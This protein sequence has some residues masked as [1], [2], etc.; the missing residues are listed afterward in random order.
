[1][2]GISCCTGILAAYAH[3]LKTGEGEKVD[4]SLV[5]SMVSSLEII[6]I[7]YLAT[8]RTPQRIGNRYEALYPYDSFQA[9]DGMLVIG[10]GNDKL[11]ALLCGVMGRPELTKDP[12]FL[13]VGDR[14]ANHVEMK[15]EVEAWTRGLTVDQ[16]SDLLNARGVPSCPINTLDRVVLDPQIAGDRDMFPEVDHPVAGR[17]RLTNNQLKFTEKKAYPHCPAPVLG[18][19]NGEI[20]E[21]LLG[22]DAEKLAALKARRVI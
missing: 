9:K 20:Y 19:D 15:E 4:V 22:F 13:V 3:R 8:G 18:Q 1:M 7:I 14:V 6:N 11:Y 17:M 2:G 5:D 21:E 16:V 10:A 12:R